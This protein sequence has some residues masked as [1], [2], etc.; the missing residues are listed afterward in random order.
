MKKNVNMKRKIERG[1]KHGV[2][3]DLAA[4]QE[5]GSSIS[6]CLLRYLQRTS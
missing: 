6:S 2:A 5:A 3:L 1:R 4:L